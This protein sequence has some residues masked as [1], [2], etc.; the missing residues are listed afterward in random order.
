MAMFSHDSLDQETAFDQ[1]E[2]SRFSGL[3][4]IWLVVLGLIVLF[5]P[6]YFVAVTLR[7]DVTRLEGK[8][9]SLETGSV[10]AAGL[11]QSL[12]EVQEQVSQFNTVLPTL[13]AVNVDWAA[14]INSVRSIDSDRV[15]L[16]RVLQ[17]G[18]QLQISGRA[19]DDAAVVAYGRQLEES[20]FFNTVVVQSIVLVERPFTQSE[21][22][23]QTA[24][25]TQ[26]AVSPVATVAGLP[27]PTGLATSTRL[28]T[29]TPRPATPAP[30]TIPWTPTPDLRDEYEWDDNNAQPIFLGQA[31]TH[32][33][34]PNFDVDN[35]VFLAK[36]GRTYE[37]V[38]V[39]LAP[40]VDTFLTVTFGDTSLTNDDAELGT[41]ASRVTIQA[42]PDADV[43]VLLRISNR[44]AYGAEMSYQLLVQELVLTPTP[45]PTSTATP[46]P[47]IPA[48]ATPDLR[49]DFEPDDPNPAPIAVNESQ[50]H[51][52]FPDGDVDAVALLVK[53]GHYYQVL[54]AV[55]AVGVD[56][57]LSVTL[58]DET[59]ENDDYDLLG[60][61]NLASAVCFAA[62][63]DDT[64]VITISNTSQQF[65]P[66]KTYSVTV[67]ETVGLDFNVK[68]VDFGQV[69]SDAVIPAQ[70]I[71]VTASV[72]ISWTAV[73]KTSWLTLD[74]VTGTTPALLNL[75]TN[76]AGLD[77]GIHEGELLVSWGAYCSRIIPVM[78]EIVPPTGAQL[79]ENKRI[80]GLNA[81]QISRQGNG[82]VEFVI[83]VELGE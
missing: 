80:V 16:S 53:A 25:L 9:A 8:A 64:A 67:S 81:K 41:L 74:V 21:L 50:S 65:S 32:N 48:T 83:V 14:A 11:N 22:A 56:T 76:I 57:K 55:L 29:A 49:D 75:T 78:I 19:I 61:G 70:P 47:S 10:G 38:T 17:N 82:S 45:T 37:I 2:G 27:T 59:W 1:P 3:L 4:V 51:N 24:V 13:T 46:D 63:V 40:G 43:D 34:Y 5:I 23:T 33:F 36:A 26:T 28:P 73:T 58:G 68:E 20:G 6:L 44:G 77:E 71:S 54:T 66:N 12:Q 35:T 15:A 52:F 69:T 31:Q 7:D 18:T 60:S 39:S 30:T 42:P 79:P 72:P 62:D